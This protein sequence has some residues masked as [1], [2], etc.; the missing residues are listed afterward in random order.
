MKRILLVGN[1]AR[2]H[3]LAETLKH[4]SQE[5]S[6]AVFAKATNPALKELAT[7]YHVGSLSDFEALKTFVGHFDPDFAI[8]GPENPLADGI[9]DFLAGMNVPSVGPLQSLAQ[10]EC[11]KSFARDLLTKYEIPGNPQFKVFTSPEGLGE[12]MEEL[13]GE[14]VVKA[15]CLKG[16]KG[17]KLSGEHLENIEDGIAYATLCIEEDGRV[18]VE[19]KFVGEEFSLICFSDG[20]TIV[21]C[22]IAQDHKRAYEGDTGPNT[23]GMGTISDA[24]HLLPFISQSDYDQAMDINQKVVDALREETGQGFK[25]FLYGG[26]IAVKNGVRLIEYNARFGDP[27]A[28]NMLGLLKTDFI[29]I[30]EAIIAGTLNELNVEFERKATVL[31]YVVPEGYPENSVKNKQIGLHPLPDGAKLYFSS[32]DEREGHLYILGSRAIAVIGY[33]ADLAEAEAIAQKAAETISGPVFFRKDIG[34]ADLIQKRIDHMVNL[35]G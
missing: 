19:E 12:F 24:N 14:Y 22:P 21:P 15:D 8:I 20:E 1:G 16:G 27:E 35:R 28:M 7:E 18:V 32:V 26:F 2:E 23:G 17:V 10:L 5:C 13:G 3:V 30:C 31:K 25:G 34:T 11:S 6:L 33:G 4:S 29:D 9:V